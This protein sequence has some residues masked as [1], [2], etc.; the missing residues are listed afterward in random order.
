MLRRVKLRH[1]VLALALIAAVGLAG[2]FGPQSHGAAGTAAA[3]AQAAAPQPPACP[4]QGLTMV[5]GGQLR[6]P[7]GAQP[8]TTPLLV[9]VMSGG[10]GDAGD[11]LKLGTEANAQGI[12]V[13]YPT[14]RAGSI[15]QLNDGMG[16][17]DVDLVT[18]ALDRTLATGCFDPN[19]VSIVG[20]SN[21]GGFATRLACKLPDRFAAVVAVSA[22]FRALDRCPRAARAS[23][24]AIHGSA[25]AIVPFKG[26][27]PDFR[28]NVPRYVARWAHRDGCA[29]RVQRYSPRRFVTRYRYT[30]CT[31]G[32]NVGIVLL[33]DMDHGWP[34]APPPWPKRNPSGVDGNRE[35]LRF[36]GNAKRVGA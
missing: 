29:P 31:A 7:P 24:L 25:D 9:A 19:R 1:L 2:A 27:Q 10:D 34:G 28:G 26:K 21:G 11:D 18:G 6:M 8:G 22:G 4:A 16:T 15:W 17:S 13:L 14:G 30:G 12:A 5:D 23:F 3:P 36:I 35:I 33:A 32:T 20:V